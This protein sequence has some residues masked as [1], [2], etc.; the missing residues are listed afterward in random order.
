[1]F[2]TRK[3]TS[4]TIPNAFAPQS[5][6]TTIRSIFRNRAL[7]VA[8]FAYAIVTS[9]RK[10]RKSLSPCAYESVASPSSWINEACVTS[11]RAPLFSGTASASA[12]NFRTPSGSGLQSA[13]SFRLW[14][15]SLTPIR[16]VRQPLSH[17]PSSPASN[18]ILVGF[19]AVSSC[20]STSAAVGRPRRM[21]ESPASLMTS[22]ELSAR[23]N[24]SS[25]DSSD[26]FCACIRCGS[27]RARAQKVA[28]IMALRRHTQRYRDRP[29]LMVS[30]MIILVLS[31]G[32]MN[33]RK[34]MIVEK[35]APIESDPLRAVQVEVPEPGPGEIRLQVR[36]C[37]VCRTDLHVAEGDLPPHSPRIIP[38]HEVVGIVDKRGGGGTRLQ[39][40]EI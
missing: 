3:V 40:G 7:P 34:A 28:Q 14:Q 17:S 12:I 8:S 38:G 39:Q 11:A 1:M 2:P 18:V 35:P 25:P 23:A 32:S 21:C 20:F 19:G 29:R 37:G 13:S 36:T 26:C 31:D 24:E 22:V 27:T 6:I 5:W 10:R 33:S 16:N 15:R 30:G 9:P 4:A